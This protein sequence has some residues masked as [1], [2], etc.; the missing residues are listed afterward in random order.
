MSCTYC[1]EPSFILRKESG[2]TLCT[3][4]TINSLKFT[5]RTLTNGDYNQ[6]L[7]SALMK[8]HP[9]MKE[10]ILE[11]QNLSNMIR[12]PSSRYC[13]K[14]CK[15]TT[16]QYSDYNVEIDDISPFN[17]LEDS[18]IKIY[19]DTSQNK[20]TP[21]FCSDC[22]TEF[23]CHCRETH[24]NRS[25]VDVMYRDKKFWSNLTHI[26]N[27]LRLPYVWRNYLGKLS[28]KEETN[29][30]RCSV[31]ISKNSGCNHMTCF[32]SFLIYC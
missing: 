16:F 21:I 24:P 4:C 29:C 2:H 9:E 8:T 17:E 14:C 5:F 20:Y 18:E 26:A 28:R 15:F 25:C 23:C 1:L 3:A 10:Y 22:K 11:C 6:I 31:V 27:N 32:C 30:P 12:S 19:I 13:H 7:E